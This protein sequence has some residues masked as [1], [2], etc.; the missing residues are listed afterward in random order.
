MADSGRCCGLANA[1][2]YYSRLDSESAETIRFLPW[3]ADSDPPGF[4]FDMSFNNYPR[5]HA[6]PGPEVLVHRLRDRQSGTIRETPP[7]TDYE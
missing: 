5:E 7:Y 4:S 6:R 3:R 1:R 2:A